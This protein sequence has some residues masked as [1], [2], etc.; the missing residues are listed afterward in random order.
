MER[1]NEGWSQEEEDGIP[2]PGI[3]ETLNKLLEEQTRIF[4]P[5]VDK[6]AKEA[7]RFKRLLVNADLDQSIVA[8]LEETVAAVV[9]KVDGYVV[10]LGA[11]VCYRSVLNAMQDGGLGE[12]IEEWSEL[13]SGNRPNETL[14]LVVD[15]QEA[16]KVR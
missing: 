14:A 11:S 4:G 9:N 1:V 16:F 12:L 3:Q 7:T 8:K 10:V 2:L 6:A 15:A 13:V 5:E